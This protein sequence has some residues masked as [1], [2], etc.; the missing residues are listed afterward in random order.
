MPSKN[1]DLPVIKEN[2]DGSVTVK[3]QPKEKGLHEMHIKYNNTHVQG[4]PFQFHVDSVKDGYVTAY[5]PGLI[6]GSAG[7]KQL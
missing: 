4:S 2:H 5:G 1:T 6:Y 7:K 3:Y